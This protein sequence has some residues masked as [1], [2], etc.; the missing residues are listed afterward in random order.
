MIK[1]PFNT[2]RRRTRIPTLR[3][4]ARPGWYKRLRQLTAM[5]RPGDTLKSRHER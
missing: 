1:Q 5:L 4:A 3:P 2:P